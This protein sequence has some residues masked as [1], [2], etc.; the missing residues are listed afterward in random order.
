MEEKWRIINYIAD[1]RYVLFVPAKRTNPTS[2]RTPAAVLCPA[3]GLR[4]HKSDWYVG[5]THFYG[6]P[7]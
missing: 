4:C 1:L 2:R 6:L 3:I 7:G 5:Q